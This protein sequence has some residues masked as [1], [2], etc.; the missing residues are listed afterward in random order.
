MLLHPLGG[1]WFSH[2]APCQCPP[3][4]GQELHPDRE[5]MVPRDPA[6]LLAGSPLGA[7]A[8]LGQCGV[9]ALTALEVASCML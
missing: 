3:G 7:E 2:I 8:T 5:A 1:L 4:D 6:V 9:E